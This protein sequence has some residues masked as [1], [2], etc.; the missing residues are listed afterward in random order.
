MRWKGSQ[1]SQFQVSTQWDK[2]K[3][4]TIIFL[5]QPLDHHI[6]TNI[7]FLPVER[8]SSL[9]RTIQKII[10]IGLAPH[11]RPT[12]EEILRDSPGRI[13]RRYEI[14]T[15]LTYVIL[16]QTNK[17]IY[18]ILV[19]HICAAVL[20]FYSERAVLHR[21]P[22]LLLWGYLLHL[23]QRRWL[24]RESYILD[25]WYFARCDHFYLIWDELI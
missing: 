5:F 10:Q 7:I 3:E 18:L 14:V 20:L 25:E 2:E 15:H 22:P 9:E 13:T 6:I 16:L 24:Q 17:K 23:H 21:P 8:D 11:K 19:T 12:R 4:A 1:A